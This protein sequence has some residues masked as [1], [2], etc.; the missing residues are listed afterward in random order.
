[1]GWR[2]NGLGRTPWVDEALA[3]AFDHIEA[4]TQP[5]FHPVV[6]KSTFLTPNPGY[7]EFGC[8]AYGCALPTATK[9]VV[10]KVTTDANEMRLASTL[11]QRKL[12]VPGVTHY[13]AAYWLPV[14]HFNHYTEEHLQ[15]GVLWRS[16]ATHVGGFETDV[17][18]PAR[19]ERQRILHAAFDRLYAVRDAAR[20]V[21]RITERRGEDFV[22]QTAPKAEQL[23]LAL[24]AHPDSVVHTRSDTKTVLGQLGLDVSAEVYIAHALAFYVLNAQKLSTS[25]T[26]LREVGHA[27]Q[28]LFARG[29]VLADVHDGNIGVPKGLRVTSQWMITDPGFAV[30]L[31]RG[32]LTDDIPLLF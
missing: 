12:V 17:I 4:R 13:Y 31:R 19:P 24:L 25:P 7:K 3:Q 27:F 5:G 16:E 20:A 29:I 30:P 1:M 23:M 32:A 11:V 26:P 6:E 21:Y 2:G 15:V 18:D 10:L 22:T 14:Y 8:G 9:G 28:E